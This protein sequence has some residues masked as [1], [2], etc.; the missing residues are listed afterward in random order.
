MRDQYL[1]YKLTDETTVMYD[2]ERTSKWFS[3][4]PRA[5]VECD[6]AM[7]LQRVAEVCIDY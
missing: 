1:L 4:G 2:P 7:A 6:Q 5:L 3:M